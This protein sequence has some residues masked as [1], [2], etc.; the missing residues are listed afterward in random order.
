MSLRRLISTRVLSLFLVFSLILSFVGVAN[1]AVVLYVVGAVA[2]V[3]VTIS[4]MFW[5]IEDA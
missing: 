2:A 1:D 3:T 5:S 4:L